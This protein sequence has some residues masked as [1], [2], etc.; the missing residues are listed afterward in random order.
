MLQ[1]ATLF[2]VN[3]SLVDSDPGQFYLGIVLSHEVAVTI[4]RLCAAQAG[5]Q[6]RE[7]RSL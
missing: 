7:S 5:G 4:A 3:L 6:R 1:D 2:P